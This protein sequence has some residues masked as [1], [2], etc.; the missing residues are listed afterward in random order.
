MP[1][2]PHLLE[3]SI[4]FDQIQTR[5]RAMSM[6]GVPYGKAVK[7]GVSQDQ[8][9]AQAKAIADD[10]VASNG[11]AGLADKKVVALIAYIQRLGTDISKPPPTPE[12]TP[13]STSTPTPATA[14]ATP[15]ATPTTAPAAR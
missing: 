9:R 6:I 13:A 12:T 1:G 2:Y 5:V 4:D 8:A 7:Q 15:A 11:P 3:E 10:V 14:P